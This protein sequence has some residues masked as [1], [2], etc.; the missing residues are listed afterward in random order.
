MCLNEFLLSKSTLLLMAELFSLFYE[1]Y[2]PKITLNPFF[3]CFMLISGRG[4]IVIRASY[5]IIFFVRILSVKL[6]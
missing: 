3:F 6:H 5:W 1:D 2:L 4:N